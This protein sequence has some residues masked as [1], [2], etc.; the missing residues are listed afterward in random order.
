MKLCLLLAPL[1]L[2]LAKLP[3]QTVQ[4]TGLPIYKKNNYFASRTDFGKMDT[5]ARWNYKLDTSYH[6][7]NGDAVRPLAAL[8][9]WRT[10]T[11]D[12]SISRKVY[13]RYWR[14]NISFEVYALR[15]SAFCKGKSQMTMTVSNCM[16]PNVGGDLIITGN[17]IFL[18][19]NVCLA[20]ARYDT[21]VDYCRPVINYIF[22]RVDKDKAATI[23]DI[24]DQFPIKAGETPLY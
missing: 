13:G 14:P 20:C 2:V 9:L 6:N 23:K 24:V 18:N 15:D 19:R 16:P 10:K 5:L 4:K 8:L 17:Y 3:A 7:G 1:L 12:D 21:R 22:S 11:I